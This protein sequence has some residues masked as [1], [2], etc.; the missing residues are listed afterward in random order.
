MYYLREH[1]RELL[2]MLFNCIVLTLTEFT[3]TGISESEYTSVS[4]GQ[5]LYPMPGVNDW[6]SR[7]DRIRKSKHVKLGALLFNDFNR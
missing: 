7:A 5:V 4:Y 2:F 1:F 6:K 3:T